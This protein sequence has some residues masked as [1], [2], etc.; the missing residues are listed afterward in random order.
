VAGIDEARAAAVLLR[1]LAALAPQP[2]AIGIDR[3]ECRGRD[4]PQHLD[5]MGAALDSAQELPHLEV[6]ARLDAQPLQPLVVGRDRAADREGRVVGHRL[7]I[8]DVEI[9][10]DRE[11]Q[12]HLVNRRPRGH[13]AAELRLEIVG[14]DVG[15]MALNV[16]QAVGAPKTAAHD[17]AGVD[18]L[19][20]DGRGSTA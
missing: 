15:E 11:A 3:L 14:F 16:P 12:P 5:Q 13:G 19:A 9:V 20:L 2:F 18:G 4:R 17:G 7:D 6:E 10:V 1:R 8:L